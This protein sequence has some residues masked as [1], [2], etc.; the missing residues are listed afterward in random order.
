MI[1]SFCGGGMDDD[2][3]IVVGPGVNI[4]EWC[5]RKCLNG[6][7]R[8]KTRKALEEVRETAFAELWGTD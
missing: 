7:E 5:A 2:R 1:C 8:A 4:C 6:I 3:Y